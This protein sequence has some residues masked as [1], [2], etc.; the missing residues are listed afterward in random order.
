MK[1]WTKNVL[2]VVVLCLLISTVS[3]GADEEVGNLALNRPCE[4]YPDR[5]RGTRGLSY[6]YSTDAMLLSDGYTD[7][8]SR[9]MFYDMTSIDWQHGIDA[10][11]VILFDL[12]AEAIVS[13]V[14]VYTNGGGYHGIT[15]PGLKVFT[16]LDNKAY[17][18]A[19]ESPAPL[20]PPRREHRPVIKVA[21]VENHRARYVAISLMARRS[22][23]TNYRIVTDEVEIMGKMSTDKT[24]TPPILDSITASG[25]KELQGV[26]DGFDIEIIFQPFM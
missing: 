25:A 12:G 11:L 20:P 8:K 4:F 24:T 21:K 15:E 3:F 1:L 23:T 13:E 19:G 14:R 7:Y 10:P 5:L 9:T 22:E 2:A 6:D 17:F 16:S 18:F 26:L